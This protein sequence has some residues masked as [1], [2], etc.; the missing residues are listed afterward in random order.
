MCCLDV[1]SQI[2][3]IFTQESFSWICWSAP[4]KLLVKGEG[5]QSRSN[6][7]NDASALSVTR[8]NTSL[9]A[10]RATCQSQ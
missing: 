2:I 6:L 10:P 9:P 1:A 5:D 8:V 3:E 4:P 7:H